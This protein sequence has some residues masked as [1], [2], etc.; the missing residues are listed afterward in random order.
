MK[1]ILL[2][3]SALA[4]L[5]L[6]ASCQQENLE[7]EVAG[8][9]VTFTVEAPAALQTKAIADGLN[10]DQLIYEVWITGEIANQTDLT[11]GAVRL[12]QA[13]TDMQYD[14]ANNR[15]KADI[16]LDLVNDQNFTVL[17][18]A[19]KK[20]LGVYK[21]D[22][23][24]AVTY[25]N[26]AAEAYAAN[27]NRL[28]A[29]YSKAF[30]SDGVT[31]T[32]TV[33]LRRPFAQVN[34]CTL[35]LKDAAQAAGDYNIALVSSKMRLESVPTKFNVATSAATGYEP[36]E[37]LANAVPSGE[38]QMITVNGKKYYY[39]GMNYVFAGTNTIL[40]YDIQT[41]LNGIVDANVN[42]E[43]QNVPL[44]E[45][46]RT[47]IIG[48]LLTSKTDYEI[49]VDAS[50]NIPDEL[51]GEGVVIVKN[52]E[53]FVAAL[54][55]NEAHLVIEL[56]GD[57]TMPSVPVEFE[58]P[59]GASTEK[60][61][62]GGDKTKTI[63]VNAN[64]NKINFV[65]QNTDW[66]YI[67]LVN[68]DAQWTINDAIITNSGANNGPWNRHDIRFYN[69][70][71]L[72]NV[73]SDKAIAL[74]NDGELNNVTITEDTGAYGLW[75]TAEGQTVSING[76]NITSTNG[77][78]AIAIKEQY[79]SAPACV[80][81]N[82]E[83]ASFVTDQK[84]A[85]L[86][87]SKAGATINW[88]EGNDITGVAADTQFA[89]WVDEDL[90]AYADKVVVNGAYC[91]VEGDVAAVVTN[92]D[93]LLAAIALENAHI[94]F[95]K[96]DYKLTKKISIAKGVTIH[97]NG[98]SIKNDWASLLFNTQTTL[99]NVTIEDMNF[100][101]NTVLDMAYAKGTVTFRNCTFS[102]V[103]GNQ[104]LHF[105]GQA[106][107]KVVFE[108]CTM[109]GRNMLAASLDV[110]EFHNCNFR[111][112]TWNTEQGNKGVGTG[113]SGVN[114]W[115]K[116]MFD[117]CNFDSVCKCCV[118]TSGVEATF[119]NCTVTDGSAIEDIVIYSSGAEGTIIFN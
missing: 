39:A 14:Q 57:Q 112:S 96:A 82:V 74:L 78:R 80:T 10:V 103:R 47:N 70:V 3:A 106:G 25:T 97:G 75:I 9:T 76:L 72:N 23:L 46:Y 73:T 55:R 16:T 20:D 71:E 93:E 108:N 62:F 101:N 102:H 53:E 12:Y 81:L 34:L 1:K 49:V 100:T 61:Y 15:M 85:V 117:N 110:V 8:K 65:H 89:V 27:D 36:M 4:G 51:V 26:L 107:A 59:V 67:R 77:G 84:A 118:K 52:S 63:T 29:F 114:M 22:W 19:Q 40:T 56:V 92:N 13:T 58:V 6:A 43:I 30:V 79:V 60:Y 28:D 38:D 35:N 95:D 24:N 116:Y 98:A 69:A 64:G 44:R 21:T 31:K 18:W 115:G 91:K 94:Y 33:V 83:N 50:F 37:F 111:E 17:F 119:T 113:W 88:L 7:P 2:F 105:D 86:V 41:K 66:N 90:R 54:K 109:Y 48:N 104:S 87:T 99:E 32:P 11:N 45:N 42:N 5:F 68:E